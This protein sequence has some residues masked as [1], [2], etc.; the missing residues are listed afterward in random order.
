M[1]GKFYCARK[2]RK[3]D[4]VRELPDES[5]KEFSG[6]IQGLAQKIRAE[7]LITEERRQSLLVGY[8]SGARKE[9]AKEV[10]E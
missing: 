1:T 3:E 5:I 2:A 6:K 7:T 9:K 10:D 4:H 8:S